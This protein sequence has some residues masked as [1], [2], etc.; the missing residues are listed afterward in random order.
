M[1]PATL[2]QNRHHHH[3]LNGMTNTETPL[4]FTTQRRTTQKATATNVTFQA[5]ASTCCM[6]GNCPKQYEKQGLGSLRP[7]KMVCLV[8]NCYKIGE[9][10][11]NEV[12]N[13]VCF[14]RQRSGG[15]EAGSGSWYTKVRTAVK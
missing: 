14:H 8:R 3:L 4:L 9:N 5:Q 15:E 13:V 10:S 2:M 6:A 11:V 12:S 7:G 1:T